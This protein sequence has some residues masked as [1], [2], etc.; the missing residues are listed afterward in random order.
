MTTATTPVPT[1]PTP[2]DLQR[3]ASLVTDAA[4]GL[5]EL[6]LVYY[7]LDNGG[8]DEPASMPTFEHLGRLTSFIECVNMDLDVMR[9]HLMTIKGAQHGAATA[10]EESDDAR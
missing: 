5:D 2:A 7:R 3:V 4:R 6:Q 10:L 8:V 9:A 1:W